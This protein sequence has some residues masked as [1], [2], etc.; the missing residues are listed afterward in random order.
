MD[1]NAVSTQMAMGTAVNRGIETD[2][3]TVGFKVTS[4]ECLTRTGERAGS[5]L[6]QHCIESELLTELL[7]FLEIR[8]LFLPFK[9]AFAILHPTPTAIWLG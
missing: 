3:A 8:V 6:W 2:V 1:L 5:R 7:T 9:N 4:E